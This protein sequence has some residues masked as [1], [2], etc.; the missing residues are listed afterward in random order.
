MGFFKMISKVVAMC[1]QH[2]A[3]RFCI[4]CR[5]KIELVW[6]PAPGLGMAHLAQSSHDLFV[7]DP[8][9]AGEKS[10]G[11]TATAAWRRLSDGTSKLIN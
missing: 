11:D 2:A 4:S 10:G 6:H 9:L 5:T 3:L 8:D 1:S 7:A